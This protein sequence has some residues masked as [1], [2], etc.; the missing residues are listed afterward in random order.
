M[1][2]FVAWTRSDVLTARDHLAAHVHRH[3]RRVV[4]L[5]PLVADHDR[6]DR[7]GVPLPAARTSSPQDQSHVGPLDSATK[8]GASHAIVGTLE[9]VGIATLISVP[10]GFATAVFLNEVGGA[11]ARPVRM[12]VDAM[13]AIPSIVAG[14]FIYT[15]LIQSGYLQQTGIAAAL[16][17][18]V[19]MLPTVTRTAEVVLRLV[20]GGLREASLAL[21]APEWRTTGQ[22]DAADRAAPGLITAVILGVAPDR[23]RDRAAAPH[24]ARERARSTSIRSTTGRPRCRCTS[25]SCSGRT[26]PNSVAA[27]VERRARADHARAGPVRDR[28]HHRRPRPRPHRAAPPPPSRSQRTRMTTD[29][30]TAGRRPPRSPARRVRGAGGLEAAEGER[31]VRRTQGARARLARHARRAR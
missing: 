11:L 27:R 2:F 9:Q 13:S 7:E 8:G 5:I 30:G 12:L 25:S 1:S 17:L 14:L 3:A 4:V 21:G 16:A 24:D 20:P 18:S 6:R 28:P 31:V 10:L 19:L 26:C 22:V 15:A 23:R 29:R